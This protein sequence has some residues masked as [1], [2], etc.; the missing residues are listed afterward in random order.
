MDVIA[1]TAGEV[2]EVKAALVRMGLAAPQQ[3]VALTPLTGGVSSLIVRADVGD[4]SL[5]VK[6]A[7]SK[8]KVASDWHAPVQRSN[9]E[10]AWIRVSAGIV[11]EAVPKLLGQDAANY[12]FAMAYLDPAAFPVWKTQL[13]A[14][15]ARAATAQAVASKL[16]AIHAATA[17]RP[18]L[19]AAFA[20]HESFFALRLDPY[21]VAAA[22]RHADCK[23]ILLEIV[24]RTD[25]ARLALIHG[26]V[27]PKN[28]LVGAE[29]PILLDAE[30][31]TYGDPAFDLAF[32]LNHLLLKCVWRPEARAGFIECYAAF[33]RT[34]LSSVAWE[35]VADI[36]RRAVTLLPALLLARI[37]G[38]SPVEYLTAESDRDKVRQFAR[39]RLL[40]KPDVSLLGL[41][42]AWKQ[43]LS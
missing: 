4:R 33:V 15:D 1:L 25:S 2:G 24:R 37:D 12:A 22:E 18:D 19:A 3:D 5:C 28:I 30:C 10:A 43:Y 6:R 42:E 41:G 20:N 39:R 40:G 8:L 16:V 14:G 29:G 35:P 36:E 27:S 31:A 7:L 34:Y 17:N 9:A 11:P 13:L 21:F 32:C 23:A 26:D 38:K